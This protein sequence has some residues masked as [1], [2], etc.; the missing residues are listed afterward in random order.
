MNPLIK[1]LVATLS[2][3]C[4]TASAMYSPMLLWALVTFKE[5]WRLELLRPQMDRVA[6]AV[7]TGSVLVFIALAAVMCIDVCAAYPKW[8]PMALCGPVVATLT[9]LAGWF[10]IGP[11]PL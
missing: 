7:H 6:P 1:S 8:K 3:A 2:T 9:V 5:D 10:F 11:L 4:A